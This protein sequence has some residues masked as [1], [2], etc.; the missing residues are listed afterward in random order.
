MLFTLTTVVRL[1]TTLFTTRGPPQPPHHGLPMKL[2][3]PHQ[4]TTGSPQ[5]SATQLT[6][7][8]P[9]AARLP[10]AP[11]NATRA[12]AY[13]GRTTTAPAPHAQKPA[14]QTQR[15]AGQGAQ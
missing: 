12:G 10:R 3:R 11:K 7:G 8:A 13:A 14:T 6:T 2:A 5:P 4:G 9:T 1:M 15:A